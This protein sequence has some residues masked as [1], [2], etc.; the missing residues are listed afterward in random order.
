M[1]F[2]QIRD[3]RKSYGDNEVLRASPS[4]WPNTRSSA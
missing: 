2:L 1:S 3:V 4:R